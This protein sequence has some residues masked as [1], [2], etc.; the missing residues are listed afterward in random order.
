M[1]KSVEQGYKRGIGIVESDEL[2]DYRI[3]NGDY[4]FLIAIR[5]NTNDPDEKH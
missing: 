1:S 5:N 3:T 2:T 4:T